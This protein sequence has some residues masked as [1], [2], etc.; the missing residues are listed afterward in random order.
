MLNYELL[1]G[2]SAVVSE[3]SFESAAKVLNITPS[4]V[5]QRVKL[6]EERL[7]ALLIIRGKPCRATEYGYALFKHTEQIQILEKKL[8]ST[9][10]GNDWVDLDEPLL[11][12]LAVNAD[13][14]GTWFPS[15][16]NEITQ[17]GNYLFD[18][19]IDSE[20]KTS[21]LLRRGDVIAAVSAD[22]K[23]IQGFQNSYLG[24]L[25][26]VAVASPIFIEKYFADNVIDEVTL[27]NAP[28]LTFDRND[29][30]PSKWVNLVTGKNLNGKTSWIPSFAGYIK[31]CEQS[32]GWG[33]HPKLQ[34]QDNLDDGSLVELIPDSK[35]DVPLYWQYSSSYGKI[36]ED[37]TNIVVTKGKKLLQN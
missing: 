25:E 21:D 13:S 33:M 22:K 16:M 17:I 10:P 29:N 6:L 28:C 20:E 32:I 24:S 34:I 11:L 27:N 8:L 36:M 5:S 12:R 31:A 23:P 7:G 14:V 3:G 37:V 9:L 1:A 15:V 18:I 4:A 30:L 35:I 26:Y 2:L 19:I